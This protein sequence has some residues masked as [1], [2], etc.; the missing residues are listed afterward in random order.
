MAID[1][2]NN[3]YVNLKKRNKKAAEDYVKKQNKTQEQPI[4][5]R[6]CVFVILQ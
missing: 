2:K 4:K 3:F 6:S 1:D 5:C